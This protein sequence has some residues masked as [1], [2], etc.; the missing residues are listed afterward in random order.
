MLNKCQ[1]AGVTAK[2]SLLRSTT[3][4]PPDHLNLAWFTRLVFYRKLSVHREM[5]IQLPW[6]W[7]YLRLTAVVRTPVVQPAVVR[8]IVEAAALFGPKIVRLSCT[9]LQQMSTGR[10][11]SA[12][13]GNWRQLHN[14]TPSYITGRR[15]WPAAW[16]YRYM[17]NILVIKSFCL[18]RC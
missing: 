8:L 14:L 16:V 18:L 5:A 7:R 15:A 2:Q 13:G 3:D 17:A 10:H 9:L 12:T 6:V 1:R 11:R 4:P